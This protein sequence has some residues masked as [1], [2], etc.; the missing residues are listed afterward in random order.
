MFVTFYHVTGNVQYS[1]KLWYLLISERNRGTLTKS[2]DVK[3]WASQWH[4]THPIIPLQK[5]NSSYHT[6]SLKPISL[7]SCP[8]HQIRIPGEAQSSNANIARNFFPSLELD[9]VRRHDIGE[10]GLDL[11][12]CKES[13]RTDRNL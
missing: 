6:Y 9:I 8:E 3:Q 1:S 5:V 7:P 13:S 10:Q 12:R 4:R 2:F 11:I